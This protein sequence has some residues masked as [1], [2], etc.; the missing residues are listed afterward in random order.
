[1]LKQPAKRKVLDNPR[2]ATRS[3]TSKKRPH[4][5]SQTHTNK[6]RRM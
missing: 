4:E 1:M 5:D 2:P 6:R 3:V